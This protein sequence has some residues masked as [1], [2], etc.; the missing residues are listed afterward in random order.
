MKNEE[1][2]NAPE[3]EK[4]LAKNIQ[5][6]AFKGG[7]N[8]LTTYKTNLQA[9]EAPKLELPKGGGALRSIGE[10]FEANPVTGT[11]NISVPVAVSPGRNGFQPDLSLSYSSGGGNGIFGMGWGVGLGSISRKTQKGLPLYDDTNETDVYIF[12]GVEDLVPIPE[13]SGGVYK[14]ADE[15]HIIQR[16]QPRI[17]GSFFKIERWTK[18]MDGNPV[19][20]DIHWRVTD[21]ANTISVLGESAMT[22]V[23]DSSDPHKIAEWKIE[24]KY[25]V[26]G[27]CIEYEY[28]RENANNVINAPAEYNRLANSDAF[29]QLYPRSIKYGNSEMYGSASWPSNNW[30]FELIFNYGE[31]HDVYPGGVTNANINWLLRPDAFSSFRTGFEIRTYRLCRKVL[32]YHHFEGLNNDDPMLVKSTE[33]TYDENKVGCQ[34]QS[35]SHKGHDES[36][37]KA[38]P[39]ISFVYSKA[40]LNP[41]IYTLKNSDVKNLP[42]GIDGQSFSF[43]DPK[44]EGINGILTENA[45]AWYFKPNLGHDNFY[46]DHPAN[47][48]PEP[49]GSFGKLETLQ[50]K[51]IGASPASLQ[52]IDGDGKPEAV[53]RQSHMAGY[54]KQKENGEWG[55]FQY[56]DA[57]PNLDFQSED[58]KFLDLNGDGRA[59]ILITKQDT[60]EWI[61]YEDNDVYN[62]SASSANNPGYGKTKI[63]SREL[64]EERGP[65]VVFSN[66]KQNIF[67]SD[68]TGDGFSDLVRIENGSICYWPNKGFGNFGAKVMLANVPTFDYPDQF[69]ANR[70]R[71]GDIDGSGTT[72]ILYL[73]SKKTV[74][75]INEAG[76]SLSDEV[77]LVNFPSKDQLQHVQ[78]ADI[79]GNGTSCL[80]WSSSHEKDK[81]HHIR[82]MDLMGGEKPYLLKE[83]DNNMGALRK[84]SYAPS[85]KHYLRDKMAGK[86][87]VTKLSFPVQTLERVEVFEQITQSRFVS[88]Y[89]YHHG[90]FD[91]IEKE[92]RGFGMVEQWDTEL[93]EEFSEPALYQV[94]SNALE[95]ESHSEP[96]YTKTW[97]HNGYF[98]EKEKI[99]KQYAKEF[100]MEDLSA[101]PIANHE[102]PENLTADELREAHRALKGSALR[103]EVYGLNTLGEKGIPYSITQ[104]RYKVLQIQAR[105]SNRFSIFRTE[106]QESF[107]YAYEQNINDPR[108][109]Q[110]LLLA[111]DEYGNPL[112]S[113]VIAYPRRGSGHDEEQLKTTVVYRENQFINH[114]PSPVSG[115]LANTTYRIGAGSTENVWEYRQQ[116][117]T[118]PIQASG[119]IS[120][121]EAAEEIPV[122][123]NFTGI[124]NEKQLISQS[125]ITYYDETLTGALTQ[126]EIAIHGLPYQTQQLVFTNKLIDA[127]FNEGATTRIDPDSGEGQALLNEAGY[128]Q[129]GTKWWKPSGRLIFD[130]ESFYLPTRSLDVFNHTTT[131]SYDEFKLFPIRMTDA[132]GNEVSAEYNYVHLQPTLMTDPNG[133][134]QQVVLDALGMPIKTLVMGKAVGHPAYTG[135]EGDTLEEPSQTFEYDLFQFQ[136]A[137]LPNYSKVIQRET[138]AHDANSNEETRTDIQFFNGLGKTIQTRAQF[139]VYQGENQEETKV[140]V[141]GQQVVNNKDLVIEQFEPYLDTGFAYQAD[142]STEGLSRIRMQYDVLGRNTRVDYEDGTFEKVEFDAWQ[143]KNYDRNDTIQ[144]SQW[145]ADRNSPDPLAA[146]EP[147]DSEERAAYLAAR[148]HNTPQTI[149]L[150]SLGRVYQTTDHHRVYNW[151]SIAELFVVS[152]SYYV[153]QFEQ[154]IQGKQ[155]GVIN[156]LGQKTEFL[157]DL[158][159]LGKE[160]PGNMLFTDSPDGGWRRM[161]I[162][163]V[164]N[165]IRSWNARGH[166]AKNE[167]DK[168]L[169]PT[170]TI[171][172][173]GY[174]EQVVA[175]TVYGESINQ[176]EDPSLYNLKGQ[177]IRAFDQSGVGR[178]VSFDFK[179]NPLESSKTLAEEY[180]KTIDWDDITS[181]TELSELDNQTAILYLELDS[182]QNPITYSNRLTYDAMN[183]PTQV[184]QPDGAIH[185]P[186]YNKAGLLNQVLVKLNHEEEYTQ[187]VSSIVYNAKGQR[188]DIYYGNDTKTK[189]E[190]DVANF[191]LTRLLTTRNFGQDILQDLNYTFDA[192]GNIVEQNDDAQQ[193]HYFSNSVIQPK[194]KYEYDSLYRLIKAT[195]R[196]K[197]NLATPSNAIYIPEMLPTNGESATVFSNYK[198]EYSYDALGNMLSLKHTDTSTGTANW[199]RTYVYNSGTAD[200]YLQSVY[201]GSTA[202]NTAQFT[203]DRHGNLL[204]M[205]HLSALNWDFQDQLQSSLKNEETTYYVYSGGQRVR[206]IVVDSSG[207]TDRIKSER[208]YLG[209]YE[210][211]KKYNEPESTSLERVAHH[212]SDDQKRIALLEV[213]IKSEG[214]AIAL[215]EQRSIQR[216]QYANHL[217]SACLE[218]NE[219]AEV[220]SYQEFHPFGS[221][222]YQMHTNDAET[223]LK[224]YQYNGKERDDETGLDYYGARYYASWLCRFISVDPMKEAR[225]WLTPYN[226]VQNNPMKLTDPTGA[227]DN[228]DE[229]KKSNEVVFDINIRSSLDSEGRSMPLV[230]VGTSVTENTADASYR[231]FIR[232]NHGEKIEFFPTQAHNTNLPNDNSYFAAKANLPFTQGPY[233]LG[234]IPTDVD[235]FSL[236]GILAETS[237]E[238]QEYAANNSFLR[239]PVKG[240]M[241]KADSLE[242]TRDLIYIQDLVYT[243][244]GGYALL[245]GIGKF[246]L[247]KYAAKTLKSSID[248]AVVGLGDDAVK[249]SN[250]VKI[251]EISDDVIVFS[252]KFGD[253]TVEGIAN[254]KLVGDKLHLNGLHLQGSSAGQVGRTNM[255]N[256]AKDLGKQFN[257]KEVIIQGG[258]RTTGKYKG[259]V[260]SPITIKID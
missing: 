8:E 141:S 247:K 100:W 227:L 239:N 254:F 203:Y 31:E 99:E 58:I 228:G 246:A 96:I 44:G 189:Y 131:I 170:K 200:N 84:F 85:T 105:E 241:A 2:Q 122:E 67:L 9:P 177:S 210:L 181:E 258:K 91:P 20:G 224:R 259:T 212:V 186:K 110:Q 169:R 153:L 108:I 19:F 87:W 36:E 102:L 113:V 128:L 237:N 213:K 218:L 202:P 134:R 11:A 60:L 41:K 95:E 154:N 120:V 17:E 93:Y 171:V 191:R 198:E 111:S 248:E 103:Q 88:R 157:Y 104:S 121:I 147:T 192:V 109:S 55:A 204:K 14:N 132:L 163:A 217:G 25:D 215:E 219:N 32:M 252:S 21:K 98:G 172:D 194:G 156:A 29:N 148:H 235:D 119:L 4:D 144:D 180:K 167:Y 52:D 238:F 18:L 59:D 5:E 222:S 136:N 135:D 127:V 225:A 166:T 80:V 196:E 116:N 130:A 74:Y 90:Y 24:R 243:A 75:F 66:G 234:F 89:A 40:E 115:I 142:P 193:T 137:A 158:L 185:E 152:N 143:Q 208:I 151:D 174:G 257:A 211:Y 145:Y 1:Q 161:L 45:D 205:N 49:V 146:N 68:M 47:Y 126:G 233:L 179:G 71:L 56:F 27:N 42:L 178:N 12:A 129:D 33:I 188:T 124:G 229:E 256:M 244:I 30:H 226:Y 62:A 125:Q 83:M 260:P 79:L 10:K 242:L 150:D 51:P 206:K 164:G 107:S 61:A 35:V 199:T 86:P 209:G 43:A 65:R 78:L 77:V 114:N 97:F 15:T 57:Y 38:F 3:N 53:I 82:Y 69:D 81:P 6:K 216:Y 223:S 187:H 39:P 175:F 207:E 162:D 26:L 16:Y 149:D 230:T 94:G 92:F 72:D 159:P 236:L 160:D 221:T 13:T 48:S 73:G 253:E 232:V 220:L 176:D 34:I 23:Y 138:H 249:A 250:L 182:E 231:F 245:K 155:L 201:T 165:P 7:Q 46:E 139:D 117:F 195:G 190:Y 63:I 54:Y 50:Q 22:R 168:L 28:Y 70:I 214:E 255:W 173:Q 183:R 64:D 106:L 123:N 37:E 240:A 197:E 118:F 133:N 112:K 251:G 184:I 76:N 101:F 140:V